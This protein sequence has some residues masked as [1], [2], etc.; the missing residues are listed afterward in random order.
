MDADPSGLELALL[1][2][3]DDRGSKLDMQA[4]PVAWAV[5]KQQ[6]WTYRAPLN[7]DKHARAQ[8]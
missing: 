7:H 5:E 3:S 6:G 8:K 4:L 1:Q 2:P